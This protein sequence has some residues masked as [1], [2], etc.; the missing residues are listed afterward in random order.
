ML[1]SLQ[2]AVALES[3]RAISAAVLT[4]HIGL[5][6]L[7]Q[8]LIQRNAR[9]HWPQT[10]V[11]LGLIVGLGLMA[12]PWLL[13]LWTSLV[14][15]LHG[16]EWQE[17]RLRWHRRIQLGTAAYLYLLLFLLIVPPLTQNSLSETWLHLPLAGWL[18]LGLL[19]PREAVR[20]GTPR[21]SDL[22]FGLLLFLLTMV[23]A[24]GSISLAATTRL[25]YGFSVALMLT[26]MGG[27]VWLISTWWG[28][29][30][31]RSG[32]STLFSAWMLR[33][34]T[35]L[36]S[37][38]ATLALQAQQA[39]SPMDFL[40]EAT[41]SLT[42]LPGISAVHWQFNG[43]S[44]HDG[45]PQGE[46]ATVRAG[47]LV[48][49]LYSH[50]PLHPALLVHFQV[51]V[52]L[53]WLLLQSKLREQ[54]LADRRYVEAV[55]E[56]GA[57]LTH[58]LK[59]VLQTISTLCEITAQTPDPNRVAVFLGQQLPLL[60]ERLQTMLEKLQQPEMA[61]PE[62]VLIPNGQWWHAVQAR[63]SQQG[64]LLANSLREKD[65]LP[66]TLFD[67]VL[68][69]LL[70]NAVNKRQHE[71]HISIQVQVFWREGPALA[72]SDTGSAV[73]D[74]QMANLFERPV[75]SAFGMGIGLMQSAQL[76]AQHHY[77]LALVNNIAGAVRFELIKVSD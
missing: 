21:R 40:K 73:A 57:R 77:Q 64:I 61:Q 38:S 49:V 76:A 53:I 3:S 37:W 39:T 6:L 65:A 67:T 63:Y 36:E 9:F 50:W 60:H 35:P 7:W 28:P 34:G 70:Q 31:G 48:L 59:N 18:V 29:K 2:L 10:L 71:G 5:V 47:D 72:V 24:L 68:D 51:L 8:P 4:A 75:A 33:L 16:S 15:A 43:Q 62:I 23:L 11:V 74:A 56:T 25:G 52:S 17:E 41:A 54:E 22:I 13:L 44:D 55:H 58:D 1:A 14:I 46:Q 32:L 30:A 26:G 69:N 45:A 12:Y 66:A 19:L 42:R 27:S 20:A